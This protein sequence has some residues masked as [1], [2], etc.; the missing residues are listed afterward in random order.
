MRWREWVETR[1]FIDEL[2]RRQRDIEALIDTP[3]NEY[4]DLPEGR[5]GPEACTVTDKKP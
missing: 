3:L 1:R 2:A 5:S 4:H